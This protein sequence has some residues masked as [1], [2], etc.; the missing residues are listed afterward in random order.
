MANVLDYLQWRGDLLF[1]NDP[2]NEI[3]AAVFCALS[4]VGYVGRVQEDALTPVPL[5]DAID[6][7]FAQGDCDNRIRTKT[8]LDLL[9]LV[10][11]T[12]RFGQ[13]KM[14]MYQNRFLPEQETQFGAMTFLLDDG[15]AFIAFR[16]TDDTLVGWKEDFN[17]S[18]QQS[19]PTQW[20]ATQ[21]VHAIA[22]DRTEPIRIGGHS[23]GGNAAVFAAARSSPVIQERIIGVYN[24]DGPGFT[25]YMIGD[26][27]YLAIVSRIHTFIPQESIIG[28]LLEHEEPY[29][30]VYSKSISI[31]QHDL[32]S[33]EVMG[34]HLIV[35]DSITKDSLFL[36]TT[37]K[38][39]F[40]SMSNQER[41]QLVDATYT[42]LRASGS[43]RAS[44]IFKL[45]NLMSYYKTIRQDEKLRK[46]LS[47]E[48][49]GLIRSAR[50]AYRQL[51]QGGKD[52]AI[53]ELKAG[54]DE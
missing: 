1:S 45:K 40:A 36:D 18:F 35:M 17:L 38:N 29:T 24:L 43:D 33:W 47:S 27:G 9:E 46:L 6:D 8:D 54:Q 7:F 51:E 13:S 25:K 44:E 23:K 34:N 32:Y 42:M 4:Y 2:F 49:L 52:N 22:M 15:T 31:W 16:G 12:R 50:N 41:N 3:D 26:P 39:W 30:V 53:G 20:L 21:Y 5:V 14:Y 48:F 11:N 28:M 37:I 19:I 10:A